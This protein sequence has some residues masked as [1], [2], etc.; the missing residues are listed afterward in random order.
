M[1]DVVWMSDLDIFDQVRAYV[2]GDTAGPSSRLFPAAALNFQGDVVPP[3]V[4][5]KSVRPQNAKVG[6]L[7]EVNLLVDRF[8]LV[9][10]KVA[11]ILSKF[12]LGAGALHPVTVLD[13]HGTVVSE[14]SY[15]FWNFGNKRNCFLPEESTG[16]RKSTHERQ[17]NENAV[18]FMPAVTADDSIALS[19]A[20]LSGPDVWREKHLERGTFLSDRLVQALRS[21]KLE[22]WFRPV[23]C[24]IV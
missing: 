2:S 9:G 16:L 19:R 15:F 5:P 18:Y 23:S 8:L 17:Q 14:N 13:H 1:S 10:P 22:K 4:I 24:R 3:I 6:A 7:R 11:A 20:C 21:N 12:D